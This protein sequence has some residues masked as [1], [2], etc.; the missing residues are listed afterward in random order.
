VT[1][2][3]QRVAFADGFSVASGGSLVAGT[4]G[5]W[6]PSY[7]IDETPASESA[8]H[9]RW[10][11]RFDQAGLATGEGVTVLRVISAGVERGW[12]RY[13][14][15]AGGGEVWVEV[16]GDGGER[17]IGGRSSLG[18]GWHRLEVDWTAGSVLEPTGTVSV[19]VD[20]GSPLGVQGVALGGGL[21]DEVHLGD[22][23]AE[24]AGGVLDLDDYSVSR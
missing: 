15:G 8:L 20:D 10:H 23:Q 5:E 22:M 3:G 13:E 21:V 6:H 1:V 16:L 14:A 2:A 7:V 19:T 4:T 11:A 12:V 17:W 18:G 9:V 24:T